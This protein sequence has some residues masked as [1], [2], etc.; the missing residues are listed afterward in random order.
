M[1]LCRS[2]LVVVSVGTLLAGCSTPSSPRDGGDVITDV[3]STE[4]APDVTFE[5][6]QDT[7]P[8][9]SG[10]GRAC[11]GG[12]G[13][14]LEQGDCE[15]GQV[16]LPDQFG[17]PNGYCTQRCGGGTR[18]PADSIC[19][20][21]GH[22]AICMKTCTTASDCRLDEGY[23]CNPAGSGGRRVCIPTDGPMGTR[24]GEACFTTG[25]GPH[26]LPALERRVFSTP[27]LSTSQE[28]TDSVAEAEGNVVFSPVNGSIGVS[29]IAQTRGGVFMGTSVTPDGSMVVRTGSARDPDN[30][31]TSDPVLAY[32]LDGRMH[33]VFLGYRGDATG[34]ISG[35]RVR[36]ATSM[37]D[38]RTW[39]NVRAIEPMNYCAAMCDKP[40]LVS[41]PGPGDAGTENLYVGY[42][43]QQGRTS[44]N[45][46]LQRSEDGGMTWS[47]PQTIASIESVAGSTV[48]PNLITPKVGPDGTLHVVYAGLRISGG[49]TVRFGDRGNRVVYRRSTDG[50]RT[51]SRAY[52]VARPTDSVVYNQ[53]VVDVDGST[54]HVVYVTGDIRGAWD[55][56]L[57]TSNDGGVTWRHRKVNDE[58]ESCAT[59]AF[60]WMVADPRRHLVHVTWM[61]NRFG[62]GA[63]VYAACP[64]DPSLPCGR[65]ELVSDA[66]FTFVTSRDPSR[67]HG[68]YQGLVLTPTGDIWASWSDTR[69]GNPAMYLARGQRS[70]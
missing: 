24:D 55:V 35:M 19:V 27:N 25:P 59:H 31:L 42:M 23:V 29:Y 16:C 9:A 46:V 52:S 54:V 69:T 13:F 12:E 68:D 17:F 50:G 26:Q 61:E 5:D 62:D 63:V 39:A 10:I 49:N 43:V 48:V 60:P 3:V 2:S 33:M 47:M 34:S 30:P 32:T 7:G 15:D 44:V 22:V 38:G 41:G 53:P 56:I 11:V 37:D 67:W 51:W 1:S 65:N 20:T 45:L 18:C 40:W 14:S 70:D 36:L 57:A 58:P 66:P 6:R 64:L 28:R 8:A 21:A 4:A